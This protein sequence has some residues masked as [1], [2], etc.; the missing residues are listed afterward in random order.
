[1]PP[2]TDR[3]LRENAIRRVSTAAGQV[4]GQMGKWLL[5]EFS[6]K[7][8]LPTLRFLV[9]PDDTAQA[10]ISKRK[11]GTLSYR[12]RDGSHQDNVM[13]DHQD[14]YK[15]LVRHV[16]SMIIQTA[17]SNGPASKQETLRGLADPKSR[18]DVHHTIMDIAQYR[19]AR[20]CSAAI[21][22]A[23]PRES[24]IE[25]FPTLPRRLIRTHFVDRNILKTADRI[26]RDSVQ[27]YN[28]TVINI[29]TIRRAQMREPHTAD[30]FLRH[31]LPWEKVNRNRP[32]RI[33]ETQYEEILQEK[34]GLNAGERKYLEAAA[35]LHEGERYSLYE[36]K[37]TPGIRKFCQD[38]A[39]AG[40]SPKTAAVIAGRGGNYYKELTK[41]PG[42]PGRALL[43]ML[44]LYDGHRKEGEH[45][46]AMAEAMHKMAREQRAGR[47][48]EPRTWEECQEATTE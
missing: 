35:A 30:Y 21:M 16:A 18:D 48:W 17:L 34:L 22:P 32:E 31:A 24:R 12:L 5:L 14:L 13:D 25:E 40:I 11:D 46:A 20:M 15:D 4:T 43:N 41:R 19:T 2:Q 8:N 38:M 28:F 7:D 26:R 10:T 9:S 1:M 3:T 45:A 6:R 29:N 39:G 27:A 47:I 23:G 37:A 33:S 44:A 42:E 36:D